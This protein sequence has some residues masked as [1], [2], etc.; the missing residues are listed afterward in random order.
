M[1]APPPHGN[2]LLINPRNEDPLHFLWLDLHG[3]YRIEPK[4]GLHSKEH[5][6]AE[7]TRDLLNLNR[8]FLIRARKNALIT[9]WDMFRVYSQLK[10]SAAEV[11]ELDKRRDVIKTMV[12]R[13]V[14]KEMIRQR[15]QIP[16][17]NA[18]FESNPEALNW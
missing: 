9:A 17:L 1:Q 6:R 16:S 5:R 8:D 3:T 2:A 11:S 13:T 15:S 10:I 12:H 14:W 7:Y 4:L 18:L